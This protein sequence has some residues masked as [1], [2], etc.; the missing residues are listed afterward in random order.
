ML[1]F[2]EISTAHLCKV[3]R[4]LQKIVSDEYRWKR[5]Y[6]Q[7]KL[8][9]SFAAGYFIFDV[10]VCNSYLGQ[11]WTI[12]EVNREIVPFQ[13]E[14]V[15]PHKVREK[16]NERKK[17]HICIHKDMYIRGVTLYLLYEIKVKKKFPY[18]YFIK[19]K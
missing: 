19:I 12:G 7:D 4:V 2:F 1:T 9:I 3:F 8:R 13:A 18:L 16:W 11:Q 10:I 6:V 17:K 15:Y 5:R 14:M